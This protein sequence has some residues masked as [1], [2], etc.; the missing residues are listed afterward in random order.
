MVRVRIVKNKHGFF[1]LCQRDKYKHWFVLGCHRNTD[2]AFEL[3]LNDGLVQWE[4]A[5]C[6]KT[7]L[8]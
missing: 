1:M 5:I 4:T 2:I 7:K 8:F 6:D 3:A